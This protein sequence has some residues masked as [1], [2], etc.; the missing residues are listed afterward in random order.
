MKKYIVPKIEIHAPFFSQELLS[1]IG[2]HHSIGR[3]EDAANQG[4]FDPFFDEENE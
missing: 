2:I 1:D 3:Q 4:E